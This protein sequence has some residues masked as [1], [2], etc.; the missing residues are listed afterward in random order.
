MRMHSSTLVIIAGLIA[1]SSADLVYMTDFNGDSTCA[2]GTGTA[3]RFIADGTCQTVGTSSVQATISGNQ[4]SVKVWNGADCQGT[5]QYG[6]TTCQQAG[7][8]T[9]TLTGSGA[10]AD[11]RKLQWNGSA[12]SV[13]AP[14]S[15][16]LLTMLLL[17]ALPFAVVR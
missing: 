1:L 13:T 9:M 16:L 3:T 6:P 10:T 4:I 12:A 7:C 11:Y 14:S 5:A 8:C 2:A 17:L 15:W